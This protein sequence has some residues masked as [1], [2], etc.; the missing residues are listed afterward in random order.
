[1]VRASIQAYLP[2]GYTTV[3]F[4]KHFDSHPKRQVTVRAELI[5]ADAGKLRFKAHDEHKK[6][7]GGTH[8]RAI[9]T[10]QSRGGSVSTAIVNFATL[11][12]TAGHERIIVAATATIAAFGIRLRQLIG[13]DRLR[14]QPA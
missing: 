12:G 3:G 9:I 11:L 10:I 1:M 13:Y 7:G 4:V 5:E 14:S 8:R 6:V 2:G